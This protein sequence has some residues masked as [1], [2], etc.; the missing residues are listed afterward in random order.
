MFKEAE[1]IRLL[2]VDDHDLLRHGL[3]VFI[4]TCPD[5][6]LVGESANGADAI[7]L[8]DAM[9]PDIVL[10]D[11][12]MPGMDG[13]TA[14]ETIHRRHPNIRVIALTSFS[15]EDLVQ[16][17]IGAGAT[18]YIMKDVSIDA[19][20]RAIRD[21]H[22]GKSTLAREAAQ[23][24]VSVTQR[25]PQP[26]YHLTSREREVLTLMT[27]GL[28]NSQI[29]HELTISRSTAKKHVS[30]ILGKLN[31]ASRTEAVARAIQHGLVLIS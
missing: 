7:V 6:E 4:E 29:A 19:L 31:T 9:R 30:N 14:I 16:R 3:A 5:F 8:C 27:H 24:L 18:S 28:N 10:M 12:M 20:A 22:A 2:I 15:H 25:P 23:A 26:E 1:R 21:A 13:P 11:L 17:A